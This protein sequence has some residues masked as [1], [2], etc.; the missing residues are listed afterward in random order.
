MNTPMLL[1]AL[2]SGLTLALMVCLRRIPEGQA[3]TL[4]RV[5]GRLRTVG[6]GVHLVMPLLERVTH[7]IR[8]FGNVVDIATPLADGNL[9]GRVYFQV[10]DAKRADAVIDGIADLLRARVPAL[11]TQ[12]ASSA[13]AVARAAHLKSELNR[14]L[15][16]RG[17][18]VTRVQFG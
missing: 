3:Y 18:L 16:P 15:N 2:L 11:A 7:K 1:L 12:D 4:R 6:A 13:D 14:E 9:R 10:L 8:L 17:V 5:D